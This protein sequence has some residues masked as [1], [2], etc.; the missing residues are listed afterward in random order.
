MR[1]SAH[2][3]TAARGS[4]P[5]AR[6]SRSPTVGSKRRSAPAGYSVSDGLGPADHVDEQ[7]DGAERAAEEQPRLAGADVGEARG[8]PVR[9]A[10]R[11]TPP[12]DR[13][14]RARRRR[15]SAPRSMPAAGRGRRRRAAAGFGGGHRGGRAGAGDGSEVRRDG[16]IEG[17]PGIGEGRLQRLRVERR[18]R[19]ARRRRGRRG[20]A[21]AAQSGDAGEPAQGAGD[22]VGGGQSVPENQTLLARQAVR[23]SVHRAR[24]GAARIAAA[25]ARAGRGRPHRAG[26]TGAHR[27]GRELRAS[28]WLPQVGQAGASAPRTSVSNRCSHPSQRYS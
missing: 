16:G 19:A 13:R 28:V 18:R 1:L 20:R 11:A 12:P 15:G 10:A 24:A 8:D 3:A 7:I 5:A 23:R 17:A 22:V 21:V 4:A 27:E 9:P 2:A 26:A 25:A 6:T 14:R